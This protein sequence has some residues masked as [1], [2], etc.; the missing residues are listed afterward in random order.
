MRVLV[1][2]GTNDILQVERTPDEGDVTQI[3]GKY[4]IEAPAGQILV[5]T[6]SYAVPVDGGDFTSLA[7]DALKARYPMFS[8]ILF[9]PLVVS[10]NSD[11]FDLSAILDN[12]ANQVLPG[13]YTGT[14]GVRAQVGR[15][16]GPQS[17]IAPN[18]TAI[19]APNPQTTPPRPGLLITDTIDISALTGGL[20]ADEFM[21]Y[22]KVF[23]FDTSHDIRSDFGIFNGVNQPAIRSM[24]EVD[25]EAAGFVVA[26]SL[27]DG[28]SYTP[29]S[30]LTPT[31]FCIKGTSIRLAFLNT[32]STK[33]YLGTY[34]LLF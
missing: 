32:Q 29:I 6:S 1:D 27:D 23:S 5:D 19:L 22:W 21:V 9:N 33:V 14:F 28:A 7:Y 15:G 20:G 3:N 11:D 31:T 25:Q 30:H 18:S 17:G 34:A 16:S 12:T 4:V 24:T 2:L 8:N 13:P 26:I 10:G